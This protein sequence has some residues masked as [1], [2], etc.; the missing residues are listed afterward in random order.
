MSPHRSRRT[1][2]AS[3][4]ALLVVVWQAGASLR[5]DIGQMS[6]WSWE[7][8]HEALSASLNERIR[9]ALRDDYDVWSAVTTW[10]PTERQLLVAYRR[11][12]MGP[13]LFGRMQ[14]LRTLRWPAGIKGVPLN[15][16]SSSSGVD[17]SIDAYVLDL[18]PD[19]EIALPGCTE[20]ARGADFRLLRVE[21]EGR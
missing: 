8:H 14:R 21:G 10:V 11:D 15:G 9:E 13:S 1:T 7:V 19:D 3:L 12:R 2:I 18:E 5:D 6:H 4:G 20:L 17:P 16:R